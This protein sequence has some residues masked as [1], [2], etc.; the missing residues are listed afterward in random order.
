[1]TEIAQEAFR[2]RASPTTAI[3]DDDRVEKKNIV[4]GHHGVAKLQQDPFS[5]V[6]QIKL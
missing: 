1:M 6:S 4:L 5:F 2:A 3:G